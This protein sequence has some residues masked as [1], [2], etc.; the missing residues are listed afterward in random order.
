MGDL[1]GSP[2]AAP[3]SFLTNSTVMGDLPGSPGAV[4]VYIY[5][6]ICCSLE[7]KALALAF[8]ARRGVR[9]GW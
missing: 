4:D 6:Y 8:A 5:I 2:G 7:A 1:P 9:L 3:F